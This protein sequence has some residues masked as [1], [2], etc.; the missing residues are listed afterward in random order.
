[1][2]RQGSIKVDGEGPLDGEH[3]RSFSLRRKDSKVSIKSRR[4]SA[5]DGTDKKSKVM[6]FFTGA[7]KE[8]A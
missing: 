7:K 4:A 1:M 5:G 3:R 2:S 8:A 6:R